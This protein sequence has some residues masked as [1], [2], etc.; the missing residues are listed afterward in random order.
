MSELLFPTGLGVLRVKLDLMRPGVGIKQP[1][2]RGIRPAVRSQL[3]HRLEPHTDLD[4]LYAVVRG[5]RRAGRGVRG[6]HGLSDLIH[7]ASDE[8]SKLV[9]IDPAAIPA[10]R[11]SRTTGRSCT[12]WTA[13]AVPNG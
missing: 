6:P 10:S 9:F 2:G 7:G 8:G 11:G 5:G 3:L 12:E 4:I 1:G 13:M